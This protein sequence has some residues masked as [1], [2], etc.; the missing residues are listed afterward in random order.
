MEQS[1][2][3]SIR[4]FAGCQECGAELECWGVQALVNGS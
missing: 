3:E 1:V 4:Y 2:V